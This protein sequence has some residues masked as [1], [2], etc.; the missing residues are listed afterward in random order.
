MKSF[1]FFFN[2]KNQKKR[3]I[4]HSWQKKIRR[5]WWLREMVW[6]LFHFISSDM[7]SSHAIW[8]QL[9]VNIR[10]VLFLTSAFSFNK[11]HNTL[12][13]KS[14]HKSNEHS[15]SL[16]NIR[17]E[18]RLCVCVCMYVYYIYIYTYMTFAK[19]MKIT[20]P[21]RNNLN[22]GFYIEIV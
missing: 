5:R 7:Y 17:S 10:F 11:W 2:I 8:V 16:A 6:C 9:F 21:N 13:W 12:P 18:E 15:T 19:W 4:K 3:K 14:S 20:C 1:F 22:I